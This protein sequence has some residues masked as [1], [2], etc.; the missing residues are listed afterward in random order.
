[1]M[2]IGTKVIHAGLAP[3]T[4]GKPFSA[5]VTLA[6]IYHAS[7]DTSASPYTTRSTEAESAR[8]LS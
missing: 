6:G 7:G 4:Q 1:M 8:I 5:G 3:A 2:R